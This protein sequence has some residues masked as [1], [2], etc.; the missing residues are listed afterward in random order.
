MWGNGKKIK[1]IYRQRGDSQEAR[2]ITVLCPALQAYIRKH[3][4]RSLCGEK[5]AAGGRNGAYFF[6]KNKGIKMLFQAVSGICF[7]ICLL[8]H[9]CLLHDKAGHCEA[10]FG[11]TDYFCNGSSGLCRRGIWDRS[12]GYLLKPF[13]FKW[14]KKRWSGLR[15]NSARNGQNRALGSIR[16]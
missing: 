7:N 16:R 12:H 14:A 11:D 8:G 6:Y 4:L 15:S 13:D 9:T 10:A 3:M 1:F 5:D 2:K